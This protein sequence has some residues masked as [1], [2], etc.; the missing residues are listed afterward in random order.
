MKLS[1]FNIYVT[2]LSVLIAVSGFFAVR[3]MYT[4]HLWI[5]RITITGVWCFLVFALIRY[6][7]LTNRKLNTFLQSL[8][9]LDHVS[10]DSTLGLSFERLNLTFNEIIDT[11]GKARKDMEAQSHYFRNIVEHADT[12][13][14]TFDEAGKIKMI[15][16]SALEVFDLPRLQNIDELKELRNDLPDILLNLKTG[17]SRL[18]TLVRSGLIRRLAFRTAGL[19]ILGEKVFIISVQDIHSQLEEEELDAWQKL[20]SILRHEIM[21]SAAPLKSLSYSLRKI[22]RKVG[23]KENADSVSRLN[24]GL[25]AIAGRSE[26]LLHFVEAYRTLTKIPDPQF[27]MIRIKNLL[28]EMIILYKPELQQ[29]KDQNSSEE[30]PDLELPVDYNLLSQVLINLV[31]NAL[32]AVADS[33][34]IIQVESGT[35]T[36][37]H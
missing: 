2:G 12:G 9:Y 19:I 7:H 36:G 1:R 32:D 31:R 28:E 3:S 20:I 22:T 6:V 4:D 33:V 37:H 16:R 10:D 27:S 35:A 34:G 14:F 18:V 25:D 17:E 15:N 26:S 13:L 29:R 21:N 8:R 30:D 23:G 24:E 11:V 5:T